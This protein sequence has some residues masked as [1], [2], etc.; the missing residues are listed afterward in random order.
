MNKIKEQLAGVAALIGVLAAIG[1]GFIKYGEVM[2]RMDQMEESLKNYQPFNPDGLVQEMAKQSSRIAV[3]EK[4]NQILEL[5]IK[6]LK[7]SSKN[8]LAN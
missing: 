5:E 4:S 7:A 8:P 1:G 6:E 3:L 2:T